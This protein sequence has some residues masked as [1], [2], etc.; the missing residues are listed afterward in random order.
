MSDLILLLSSASGGVRKGEKWVNFRV[1]LE[2]RLS[3][4]VEWTDR[5]GTKFIGKINVATIVSRN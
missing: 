4:A 5:D 2:N 3:G 1:I